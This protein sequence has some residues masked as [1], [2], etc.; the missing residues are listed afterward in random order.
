[1]QNG[2]GRLIILG[3]VLAVVLGCVSTKV[4]RLETEQAVDLSDRWNDT[5]S[6]LVARKMVDDVLRGRWIDTFQKKTGKEPMVIIGTVVNK[7][8]D[9]IPTQTF[10]KDLERE[11]THSGRVLF[12]ASSEERQEVREERAQQ[13][14]HSSETTAKGLGKEVAADYM[15]KGVISSFEEQVENERYKYFQ[16]TLELIDLESNTKVWL[17]DEKIKKLMVRKRFGF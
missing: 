10:T 5:D 2:V 8:H 16:V 17:G 15:L 12:V 7:S 13:Q 3:L 9:H 14:I 6:Q 11:L 4:S 1:M